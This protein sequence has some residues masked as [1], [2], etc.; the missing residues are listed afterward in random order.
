MTLIQLKAAVDKACAYE[1]TNAQFIDVKFA[2]EERRSW[3]T[4]PSDK[5]VE[6]AEVVR[7][8]GTAFVIG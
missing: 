4:V 6:I 7:D 8:A 1:G 5:T 3:R 2:R